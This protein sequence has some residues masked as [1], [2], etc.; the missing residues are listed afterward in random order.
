MNEVRALIDAFDIANVRG[1][2][3]A[4]ATVVSVEGPSYRRPGARMLI[5]ES[6][7]SVGT[8]SAGGLERD[9]IEHAKRVVGT[10]S[11]KLVEYNTSSASEEIVWGLGLGCNGIVLVLVE[12][13]SSESLYVGALRRSCEQR[14]DDAPA[15][16][17]TLYPNASS[18][19]AP[20]RI[21]IATGARLLI[22]AEGDVSYEN[23]GA[24]MAATVEHEVRAVTRGGLTATACIQMDSLA[25]TAFIEKLLPPVPL[26]V[27]GAGQDVLPVVE[28]A[29]E[30]GWH[31][32]VVDPE[33]RSASCS[34]FADA[35]RVTLSPPQDVATHVSLT[36]RTMTLVMSHDYSHDFA[37]LRFL[38]TSPAGYIGVM[39]PRK[40]TER[41]LSELAA[42]DEGLRL[43]DTTLARLHSPAG[44]DIGASGPVEIALSVIAEIR[45]VMDRRPG[46]ML[47]ESTCF[48]A[49]P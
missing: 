48:C 24:D 15:F 10:G 45:A 3:C 35:D 38:L 32:E 30:L 25:A 31:T 7:H 19:P 41:M 6:G 14:A 16:V 13:V 49:S 18:E 4:L 33:A 26:V 8:I 22:S 44:L 23:L 47:R 39:G 20:G 12:P 34:R 11:A 5:C 29:R 27:F 2:R 43:D 40:R 36:P 46:G 17:A 1:E 9:V 42:T 21:R 28:L 37:S